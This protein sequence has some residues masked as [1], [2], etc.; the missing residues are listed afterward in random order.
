MKRL[1]GIFVVGIEI[2]GGALWLQLPPE[3]QKLADLGLHLVTLA[4][5]EFKADERAGKHGFNANCAG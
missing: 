4:I 1:V 3:P 5:P 2:A